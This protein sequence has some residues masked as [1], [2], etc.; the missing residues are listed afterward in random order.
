MEEKV[1]ANC[2]FCK[3]WTGPLIDRCPKPFPDH[4]CLP[5]YHY[6]PY[7]NTPREGRNPDDWQPRVQLKKERGSGRLVLSDS[8]SVAAFSDKFIVKPKFVV[9]HLKHLEVVD[10]KKKKRAEERAKESQKAKEKNYEDYAWKDLCEDPTKLQKLRVPELNKYLK[11]HR[12]D[13]HLKSTKHDKVK[14]IARHW[15]LQM[16]P[17]RTD[18]LQTRLR[19]KDSAENE[20]L[21]DIDND[22]SD[23][24]DNSGSESSSER[25][26]SNDVILA[27]IDDDEEVAFIDDEEVDRPATTRSGRAI[28]R[29][30]EI[31]FSS[32]F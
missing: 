7:N 1:G 13:K 28:T 30:S 29:R 12:L 22:D 4:S 3:E 18:L 8:E 20:S 32:F 11:H 2:S 24:D 9:E 21:L 15:L 25:D 17:E 19:E 14:V 10:F 31:D 5:E 6:L 26:E 23:E 27:F 16:N